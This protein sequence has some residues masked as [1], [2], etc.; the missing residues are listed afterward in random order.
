MMESNTIEKINLKND[1]N[2]LINREM[3]AKESEY[4]FEYLL[5]IKKIK[6]LDKLIKS[7]PKD[8]IDR[9]IHIENLTKHYKKVSMCEFKLA[10]GIPPIRQVSISFKGPLGIDVEET[11]W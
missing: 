4:L 5:G 3:I 10:N 7:L 11:Y 6:K 1:I 9:D 2:N 8:A